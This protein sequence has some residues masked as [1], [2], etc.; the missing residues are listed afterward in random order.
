MEAA[1]ATKSVQKKKAA[2]PAADAFISA[3]PQTGECGGLAGM[4][5]FLGAGQAKLAIGAANDPFEMEADRVAE[6]VTGRWSTPGVLR[7]GGRQ[8]QRKC[9]NGGLACECEECRRNQEESGVPRLLRRRA[10]DGQEPS[11]VPP[12]VDEV[13]RSPGRPLDVPTRR[14][15]EGRFGRDFGGVGVHTDAAAGASAQAVNALAYTVGTNI[16]FA[17]GE[18]SPH[19][20]SGERLLAHELT[21]VVQQTDAPL[22]NGNSLPIS[23]PAD[24]SEKEATATAGGQSVAVEASGAVLARE[25]DPS[26][27]CD[28]REFYEEYKILLWGDLIETAESIRLDTGSPYA[29]WLFGRND[30]VATSAIFALRSASWAQLAAALAPGDPDAAIRRGRDADADGQ[31]P[32]EYRSEVA[33]ELRGLLVPRLQ[34]SVQRLAPQ[35]VAASYLAMKDYIAKRPGATFYEYPQVVPAG[36]ALLPSH[37]MDRAMI[38]GLTGSGGL[39]GQMEVNYKKYIDDGKAQTAEAELKKV[40]P[41]KQFRW[42]ASGGTWLWVRVADPANASK[43]EVASELYG[44]PAMA[45]SLVGAAPLFGFSP[46]LLT[47]IHFDEWAKTAGEEAAARLKGSGI[48]PQTATALLSAVPP[49]GDPALGMMGSKL[50]DE[51]A[52]SQAKAMQPT[53]QSQ[54]QIV[55][56]M[57]LSVQLLDEI[58]PEALSMGLEGSAVSQV[59][60]RIDARSKSLAASSDPAESMRWD[61]HATAEY[62]IIRAAANGVRT[63]SEQYKGLAGSSTG[64]SALPD[65]VR[66]PLMGVGKAYLSA[67]AVAELVETGQ[68][69]IAEAE[70]KSKLYPIE[71]MEGILQ[72]CRQLLSTP[73]KGM[74][75]AADDLQ[76][77]VLRDKEVVLRAKLQEARELLVKDPAKVQQILAEVQQEVSDL[78]DDASMV[79]TMDALHTEWE[80]L[81]K[82][83][84]FIGEFTGKNKKYL[85]GMNLLT[86]YYFEFYPIYLGYMSGRPSTMAQARQDLAKLRQKGPAIQKALNDTIALIDEQETRE[87][88]ISLGLKIAALVAIA[89]VTAGVGSYVSGALM[90]GA[91]WGATTAGVV[92]ATILASGAEAATFTA[93]STVLLG[94]DP[95]Q[96]VVATFFENWALFGALKG[97]SI[98]YEAAVGAQAGAFIVKGGNIAMGLAASIGYA[99]AKADADA[100]ANTGKGLTDEQAKQM[101]GEQLVVFIATALVSRYAAGRFLE[102]AAARGEKSF[103]ADFARVDEA[104]TSALLTARAALAKPTLEQAKDA[105][106]KD[107]EALNAEID[108]FKKME[109][110][111]KSEPGKAKLLGIDPAKLGEMRSVNEAVLETRERTALALQ[112]E[113][114]GGN[115]FQCEP[116]KLP[117]ILGRYGKLGDTIVQQTDPVTGA[118]SATV[119][120]K[121]GGAPMRIVEQ[122]AVEA[123]PPDP[124]KIKLTEMY[125]DL[126]PEAKEAFDRWLGKLG[127]EKALKKFEGMAKSKDGLDELLKRDAKAEAAKLAVKT[128]SGAA[129]DQV[130]PLQSDAGKLKDEV[131]ASNIPGLVEWLKRLNHEMSLLQDMSSGQTAADPKQVQGVRNNIEGIRAEFED[132]VKRGADRANVPITYTD[133]KGKPRKL[134]IDNVK[135][136]KTWTEVKNKNPFTI[137]SQDW[138]GEVKPKAEKMLVAARQNGITDIRFSFPKG[139]DPSVK[140]ALEAMNPPAG[141]ATAPRITVEGDLKLA[142]QPVAAGGTPATPPPPT[143]ILV[144]GAEQPAEFTYAT[145]TAQRGA[146]VTVVNPTATPASQAYAAAGGNFVQGKIEA[147]PPGQTFNIIREDFPFPLGRAFTPTVEF[148]GQRMSRLA[149]GGHWMVVTESTE[150]AHTLRGVATRPGFSVAMTEVP[151]YHEAT[152]QS[153]YAQEPKRFILDVRNDAPAR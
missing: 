28:S 94:K 34:E 33:A 37:P 15:M 98:A 83:Q 105:L 147:L 130:A 153:P 59:R 109:E 78:Q 75:A 135:E 111:A 142:G 113:A 20:S 123:K 66:A 85:D 125:K 145:E 63:A 137:A 10:G 38:K 36:S 69:R 97:L 106:A 57:R 26:A 19:S 25:T 128:P 51:A 90:V 30:A 121:G 48:S 14:V 118:K 1:L 45:N 148:A 84:G 73:K 27:T 16:V 43:E 67:A 44:D 70:N 132:A 54:E 152:P 60:S 46:R 21:H 40:R 151:L 76:A 74:G 92:G 108:A 64:P 104:R 5:L 35:Y 134:D 114:K 122:Q 32:K 41:L 124:V 82:H 87:R 22:P 61:A 117:D 107:A 133:E 100:K 3:E 149:P 42:E 68:Q 119:T 116:G 91:G 12:I 79:S 141:D 136:G 52:L 112:L 31:A 140:T 88:W 93:L 110:F 2:Q 120:P 103:L 127:S 56:Q 65:Y 49:E 86:G 89:V 11:S 24:A 146:N 101:I 102:G 139:V 9:A 77:K 115:L 58:G 7:H 18:Y 13:L 6:T 138:T 39:N 80:F 53:G 126:S 129:L 50:S 4:P 72:Y 62:G 71:M 8:M 150:F 17:P 23:Q 47:K 81:L 96:S 144:V 29:Y 143:N 55:A 99:L 131:A 95:N